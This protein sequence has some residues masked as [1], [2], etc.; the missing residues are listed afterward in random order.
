MATSTIV[1]TW[2]GTAGGQDHEVQ[3]YTVDG[4]AYASLTATQIRDSS[5]LL[6][7]AFKRLTADKAN[8]SAFTGGF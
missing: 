5:R 4:T 7:K 8:V 3:S 2:T 1:I 6:R